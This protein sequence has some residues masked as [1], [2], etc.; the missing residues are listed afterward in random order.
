MLERAFFGLPVIAVATNESQVER[1]TSMAESGYALYLG[2]AKDVTPEMIFHAVATAAEAPW[3]M[4]Q[5]SLASKKLVDANGALRVVRTMI[6]HHIVIRE[7]LKKDCDFLFY[8]R[9]SEK[10]REFSIMDRTF[11]LDEHRSW[12]A[13]CMGD[14]NCILL[15]GE[16][17]GEAA[18]VLRYDLSGKSAV[19]S[20]Y[21][22]PG[23]HG[24]GYGPALLKAGNS[25]LKEHRQEI[26]AVQAHVKVNNLAS[27]QAFIESGFNEKNLVLE[28]KLT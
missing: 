3:L 18:G 20:V 19:V 10:N 12:F 7:A 24:K 6:D 4:R 15:I 25:W 23:W 28:N 11:T 16:S 22:V 21:L 13:R 8:W 27:K 9:N 17:A 26:S 5:L 2:M 1:L 14:P